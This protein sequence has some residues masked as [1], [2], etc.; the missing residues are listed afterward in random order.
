LSV[1][2]GG[3]FNSISGLSVIVAFLVAA[4]QSLLGSRADQ[5]TSSIINMAARVLHGQNGRL[6]TGRPGLLFDLRE[7]AF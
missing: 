1:I 7:L 6:H 5:S 4:V 3:A 2:N